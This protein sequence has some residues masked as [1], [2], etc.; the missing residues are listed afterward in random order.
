MSKRR[1]PHCL[2]SSLCLPI[3]LTGSSLSLAPLSLLPFTAWLWPLSNMV[4][5]AGVLCAGLG[6]RYWALDPGLPDGSGHAGS[7]PSLH[8]QPGWACL[9][10]LPSAWA[11]GWLAL[12]S[13]V[14]GGC[15]ALGL[16]LHWG[17][18]CDSCAA[19]AAGGFQS[20]SLGRTLGLSEG[21]RCAC[22]QSLLPRKSCHRPRTLPDPVRVVKGSSLAGLNNEL[23]LKPRVGTAL[24][25]LHV[26]QVCVCGAWNL[27]LKVLLF[28]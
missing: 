13:L 15:P 3:L 17:R 2:P 16:P 5:P 25:K 6:Y 23:S 18:V 10:S 28:L 12:D 1:V 20:P 9:A 4:K 21:Q 7:E 14:P 11:P 24:P 22:S 27:S 26:L 19:S 8:L